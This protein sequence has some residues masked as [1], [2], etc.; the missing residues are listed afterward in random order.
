MPDLER[1]HKV[2]EAFCERLSLLTGS[3]IR[4]IE[5]PDEKNPG[6]GCSDALI[7]RD[8]KQ[9]ALDQR[10]IESFTNHFKDD[11]LSKL[12]V[13]P[14]QDSL[15]GLYPSHR[16]RVS[17][18][19]RGFPKGNRDRIRET[20]REGCIKFINVTPG[21]GRVHKHHVAEVPCDVWISKTPSKRPGCFVA[22]VLPGDQE[23][24]LNDG[25]LQ[26]LNSKSNQ[27]DRFKKK[28]FQTMLLLDSDDF[29][30]LDERIIADAFARATKQCNISSID[31]V[32]L[33]YCYP[34]NLVI[35]PL[36]IEGRTYPNLREYDAFYE[37][38]YEMI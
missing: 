26:A 3:N 25:I 4:V 20:L 16:I 23:K 31:D 35:L 19:V 7:D 2:I 18:T 11:A 22:R 33:F 34:D 17:I 10:V 12:I 28:G 15:I 27:F 5:W 29:S 21:D 13:V 8:S 24:E 38:Q 6:K 14:L 32:Y 1:E 36:K 37:R 30:S 9:I